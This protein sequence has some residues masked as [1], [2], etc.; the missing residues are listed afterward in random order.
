MKSLRVVWLVPAL[1]LT[2]VAGCKKTKDLSDKT[3]IT[4]TCETLSGNSGEAFMGTEVY[5]TRLTDGLRQKQFTLVPA[6]I[7]FE[8]IE[9]GTYS[10]K[11]MSSP[12]LDSVVTEVGR[13][14]EKVVVL[15]YE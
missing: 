9:P 6:T 15:R 5:I 4:V 3:S 14:E 7:R 1:A 8:N 10:V 13:N 2:I 12:S 11:G